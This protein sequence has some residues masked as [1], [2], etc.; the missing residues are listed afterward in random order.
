MTM[1]MRVATIFSTPSSFVLLMLL[2]WIGT[3]NTKARAG[4]LPHGE[5][6]ALREIAK[7]VGKKDWNFSVDPCGNHWQT[8]KPTSNSEA[9]KTYAQTYNNSLICN[10]SYPMGVCH[11]TSMYIFFTQLL[12]FLCTNL[13][14]SLV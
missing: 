3:T 9:A 6:Q 13:P 14:F 10:C 4:N 7:Q 12:K 5:V 2:L 1:K 8:P 11:V